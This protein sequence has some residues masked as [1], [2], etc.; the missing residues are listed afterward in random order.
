MKDLAV[1]KFKHN[2][3]HYIDQVHFNHERYSLMNYGEQRA[4]IMSRKEYEELIEYIG[5]RD[6][7]R[8]VK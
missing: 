6:E 2:I 7:M 3:G 1:T 5:L 8:L 4:V